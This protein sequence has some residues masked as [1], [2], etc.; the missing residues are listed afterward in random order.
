MSSFTGIGS[1]FDGV[2][3]SAYDVT[4][5]LPTADEWL[6]LAIGNQETSGT[7]ETVSSVVGCNLTWTLIGTVIFDTSKRLTWYQGTGASPSGTTITVTFGAT[8]NGFQAVAIQSVDFD[9]T[10]PVVQE[11]T[12]TDAAT[13]PVTVTLDNALGSA[14]NWILSAFGI[15]ANAAI[16]EESG[17]SEY[18]TDGIGHASPAS[19]LA[20]H[21]R[22]NDTALTA[23]SAA[24]R[25]WGKY[26]LEIKER[27]SVTDQPWTR[28]PQLGPLLAQ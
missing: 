28:T 3:R 20:V 19:R 9:P 7:P 5:S 15:D 27:V 1:L 23:D 12:G 14:N 22:Q 16:T 6:F 2:D 21:W 10:T 18:P 4:V 8:T 24:N 13:H 26:A 11:K 17:A 25:N